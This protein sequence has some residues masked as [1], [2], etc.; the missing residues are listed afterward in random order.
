M[1]DAVV[2]FG[3]HMLWELLIR[4]SNRFKAVQE[5]AT[6][7]QNDL[8][9][10][11]SFV[12][13]AEA[14]NKSKSER[15]KTCVQEIVEIVYDAEDIIESF[16]IN[17]ERG[18][19]RR[20]SKVIDN[21][22][23]FGVREIINKVEEEED[24]ET[25]PERV[26]RQ[27]FPSVSESSLVGSKILL[28]S[29]NENVGL[30]PDLRCIIFRP[31]FLTHDDSW[32][33]FQ[34]LALIERNDIDMS[35]YGNAVVAFGLQMLWELLIRESNRLKAVHEQATELQNDLRRLK[36]FVK[37]A[38]ATN[39][40]KSERV[41]NCI[42]EIVDIVYDAEDIIETFLINQERGISRRI[43]TVI[44]SMERFGVREFMDKVEEEDPET[45]PERVMRQAFPS[46]SES[47]LVGLEPSVEELPGSL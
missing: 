8:R 5:Q 22:E 32:E 11:K 15:V 2:A 47:S 19:S 45:L 14:T 44:D 41:K 6:E 43:S 37:D 34:K 3:L 28:T 33:V 26:M 10:L 23:K 36:S 17:Q 42:Q 30:H 12:K 27:S 18:I 29:R 38:E 16:L 31:R 35:F 20:I 40:S 7:L 24:Q 39:K 1:A 21:M 25:L 4:E 13:D 46:V 9:R